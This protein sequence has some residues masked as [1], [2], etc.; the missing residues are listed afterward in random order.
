MNIDKTNILSS[1]CYTALVYNQINKIL[2]VF[3]VVTIL[4][5]CSNKPSQIKPENKQWNAIKRAQYLN[6]RKD[7]TTWDQ[8]KFENDKQF[9]GVG[10]FGPFELG[11]FPVPNYNLVGEGSFKGLATLYEEL[12]LEDKNI[13][14][15]GFSIGKNEL[16]KN[17]LKNTKD[18]VFFQILVLTDT[19]DTIN[20][21]LNQSI[22]ISRN[23]PD[24]LGQGFIKTKNNRI[25]YLAFQTAENNA[26]AIINTRLFDLNYGKTILIAPQKDKS[27]K[28]MQIKSSQISSD[29][30]K[31][32]TNELLL[33]K[34]IIHF[35]KKNENI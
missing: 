21:K 35:F 30:I 31:S 1:I 6:N 23:H 15:N 12:K 32:Y 26:Y 2:T 34:E 29:S 27:L 24:Y 22:V 14:M 7:S 10:D 13:I 25:D 3:T 17:R 33:D 5:S 20:Y 8:E 9:I 11:A 19:I 16:N 18:E 28:S 4:F